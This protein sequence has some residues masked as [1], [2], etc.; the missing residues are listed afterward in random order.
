MYRLYHLNGLGVKR[1]RRRKGLATERLPLLRPESPNL[2]WS[3][4]FVMDALATGR[5]IK[6]LTCVDDFTKEC[7]TITTAFGISGVQVTR[8]LD[9]IALFRGYPATIRTDL[10]PEFTCRA[11]DQWAYEHGVELR[12]IQPGRPTQNGF[13]E[14]FNGRFRDECLNEHWFSDIVHARKTINDWRQD[15]NE[16]RPHSALNYQTPSEFAARWRNGKCEGK[17]TD[18]TN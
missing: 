13:I 1:R 8:I 16:C 10:G 9:S 18:L 2:P 7:L 5:R 15:Y 17:Q 6:C 14:S 3:M 12:L 11:L 4:D